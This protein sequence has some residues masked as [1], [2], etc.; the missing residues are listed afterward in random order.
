MITNSP[1][2]KILAV[3]AKTKPNNVAVI[4]AGCSITYEELDN[5]SNQLALY[6]VKKKIK[7]QEI[8][9]IHIKNSIELVVALLGVLKAGAAYLPLDCSYPLNRKVYMVKNANTKLLLTD[10]ETLAQAFNCPAINIHVI[11]KEITKENS[12]NIS[13]SLQDYLYVL[14]TSGSTGNPKGVPLRQAG[15]LNM[16]QWYCSDFTMNEN[17]INLVFSSFAYDLTQKNILST[18]LSG[19]TIVLYDEE[20]RPDK[21][22]EFIEKY[23]VTIINCTP[24]AFYPL[25][26]FIEDPDQLKSLRW[27]FLGGEKIN[28]RRLHP[29]AS[30]YPFTQVVN[31]YG[32][33]E[34]SDVVCSYVLDQNDILKNKEVPLGAPING[35]GVL[36]LDEEL[37]IIHDSKPGEVY[38]YGIC[39]GDGYINQPQLTK[40][41]FIK[42]LPS[43]FNALGINQLYR[44]GDL[45]YWDP[46]KR[47]NFLGRVD[48]QI[49]LR[50]N[51][52]E[53]LEID[54]ALER[55]KGI[56]QAATVMFEKEENQILISF[57][58]S[59]FKVD[60]QELKNQASLFLPKHMLPN[61]IIFLEKFPLTPNAKIDKHTLRKMAQELI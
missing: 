16:L 52:I 40:E 9:A 30:L 18:L 29:I 1:I 46:H 10:D 23:K 49:K 45:A 5:K 31:T 61:I 35:A 34:C 27:I 19:G 48:D 42:E 51:R 37:N 3:Q 4:S 20:Y 33:T 21:I 15:I 13:Y 11:L 25:L 43:H 36:V 38:L 44:V 57:C 7:P 14:Y 50:G 60:S 59:E 17:D 55:Q 2:Q 24:S 22:G 54:K 8:V 26:D 47:L 41:R 12:L 58:L 6:L 28:C 56:K 53:L 39:L 32:P